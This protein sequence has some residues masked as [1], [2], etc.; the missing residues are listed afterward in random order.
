VK[1]TALPTRRQLEAVVDRT[2][3]PERSFIWPGGD[4]LGA[5]R[6]TVEDLHPAVTNGLPAREPVGEQV[7]S[8]VLSSTNTVS[9]KAW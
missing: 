5:S 3:C 6:D 9:P 2:R 1:L 8:R 4:D 7:A